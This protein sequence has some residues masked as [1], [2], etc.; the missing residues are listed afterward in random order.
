MDLQHAQMQLEQMHCT[1]EKRYVFPCLWYSSK[2]FRHICEGLIV[3]EP[4]IKTIKKLMKNGERV[5]LM[6]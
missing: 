6:P 5:V 1:I 3:E 2:L 4:G